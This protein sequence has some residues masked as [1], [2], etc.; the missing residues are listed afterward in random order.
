VVV[1]VNAYPG[2]RSVAGAARELAA[3]IAGLDGDTAPPA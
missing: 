3:Y 1:D 2:F